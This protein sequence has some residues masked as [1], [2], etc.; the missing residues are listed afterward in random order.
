MVSEISEKDFKKEIGANKGIAIVDFW[1]PWCGPCKMLGPIF[2][3]LAS[4]AQYSRM[5]FA[6]VNIDE[7]E[8][9]ASEQGIMS[10]PCIVFFK[11]GEEVERMVGF[12]GEDALKMKLNKYV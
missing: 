5:K 10:I 8:S 9:L 11:D 4:S 3:R 7:N 2:E 12:S 6:K 1:A